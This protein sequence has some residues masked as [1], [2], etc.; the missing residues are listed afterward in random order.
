MSREGHRPPPVVSDDGDIDAFLAAARAA[1]PA[2]R[3]QGRLLFVL[4]ATMSRERTWDQ[5]AAVQAELFREAGRVG[6]LSVQLAWFRGIG[7]FRAY[8]W[9]AES[10]DLARQMAAVRCRAGR[11]QIDR[12]FAHAAAE[13]DRHPV[14]ALVYAGD[15]CEEPA[16]P[17]VARAGALGMQGMRLFMFQEGPDPVVAGIFRA[18]ARVSGGAYARFGSGSAATLRALLRATAVYAAGGRKALAAHERRTGERVLRLGA[19]R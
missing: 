7:E 1:S 10:D 4:D 8:P 16:D 18:I 9:T 3:G 17:L 6:G 19:S 13:H 15:A 12:A 2:V 14:A 5:A 11:T